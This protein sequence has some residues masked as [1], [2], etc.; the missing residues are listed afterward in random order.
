MN[1]RT[2][3]L[4]LAAAAAAGLF[5][6]DKA[7]SAFWFEPWAKVTADLA[8]ADHEIAAARATLVQEKRYQDDW[9]KVLARLEK[10]RLPDVNTHFVSHL[11]DI[12]KRVG[13][14]PDVS[15]NPQPQQTGD[16][17]EYAYETK[18]KLTWGQF[19]DLL[20]ELHQS[21]EFVKVL[22]VGVAS[23]YEREDRLD[24]ELKLSTIEHSPAP[25]K[26]GTGGRP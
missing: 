20:A 25:A 7:A 26:N 23:Q 1:P 5:L 17:K 16:F 12:C 8:K 15:G 10:P 6:M 19:V 2:R 22:K 4:A 24:V 13:V 9:A 18:F 3:I 11:G 21:K 14:T